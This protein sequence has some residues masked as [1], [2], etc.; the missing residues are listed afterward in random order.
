MSSFCG[1]STYDVH[2]YCAICGG[3][4]ADVFRTD[5]E[6]EQQPWEPDEDHE[7]DLERLEELDT[8]FNLPEDEDRLIPE[9]VVEQD[10]WYSS[11]RARRKRQQ[12]QA[13]GKR[14]GVIPEPRPVR[15]AY[16]G[17]FISPK[18][19]RWTRTLRALVDS[20]IRHQPAS[21][22]PS[23]NNRTY[24]TGRGRVRKAGS[25]ADA[26]SSFEDPEDNGDPNWIFPEDC[27]AA[28]DYGFHLYNDVD[29]SRVDS[30]VGSIPFHEECKDMLDMAID[31]VCEDRHLM[32]GIDVSP[33]VLWIRLRDL[34]AVS[35]Q[36]QKHITP[37]PADEKRQLVTRLSELDYREALSSGDGYQWRHEVGC[38]WV[39]ADP[40]MI[41]VRA[42]PLVPCI[43]SMSLR[44]PYQ[45]RQPPLAYNDP[46]FDRL[47]PEILL[48]ISSYLSSSDLFSLRCASACVRFLKIPQSFYQRFIEEDFRHLRWLFVNQ[49]RQGREA[50]VQWDWQ[51]SFE[52]LKGLIRTPSPDRPQEWS[53]VDIGLK[54]RHRI[55]KI[56]KPIADAI[57][58]T[59]MEALITVHNMP[60]EIAEETAVVRGSAGARSQQEG[61]TITA[62]LDGHG[63]S[64][65]MPDR[66]DDEQ[67]GEG[68]QHVG[69]G[70]DAENRM[71]PGPQQIAPIGPTNTIGESSDSQK[72][73]KKKIPEQKYQWLH[74]WWDA[75]PDPKAPSP[76]SFAPSSPDRFSDSVPSVGSLSPGYSIA[77][78][79]SSPMNITKPSSIATSLSSCSSELDTLIRTFR[80][81]FC[82][83]A[84]DSSDF[85]DKPRIDVMFG[86]L[87][88]KRRSVYLGSREIV[89]FVFSLMDGIIC[90]MKVAYRELTVAEKIIK[91]SDAFG[92]WTEGC[93]V[94]E[95]KLPTKWTHFMGLTGFMNSAGYFE[96]I[97]VLEQRTPPR[98]LLDMFPLTHQ[99]GSAWRY[100]RPIYGAIWDGPPPPYV[101]LRERDGPDVPD[102]RSGGAEWE[103]FLPTYLCVDGV[104]LRS[105]TGYSC[106]ERL[107]GLEFEYV[108]PSGYVERRVL[109]LLLGEK[110]LTFSLYPGEY[111]I[112]CVVSFGQDGVYSIQFV[113]S[114][115]RQSGSFGPKYRGSYTVFAPPPGML[116]P[117]KDSRRYGRREEINS[118]IVGLHAL[119][120][121]EE[122]VFLQL[123]IILPVWSERNQHLDRLMYSIPMDE[124]DET[125]C[126]W[127]DGSPPTDWI[128]PPCKLLEGGQR[129]FD[130]I[131]G[132][133]RVPYS[134]WVSFADLKRVVIYGAMRG[135]R[136]EYHDP[137]KPSRS[138]GDVTVP[139]SYTQKFAKGKVVKEIVE[140]VSAYVGAPEE[141]GDMEDDAMTETSAS[142]VDHPIVV[143]D[144]VFLVD[145]H[146]LHKSYVRRVNTKY[147]CGI[148]L[149][150]D[151][152][153]ILDWSPAFWPP[154][155]ERK[156]VAERVKHPWK[157][158]PTIYSNPVVHCS[159][160][161]KCI[162]VSFEPT[163]D[164][165][166]TAVK[167]YIDREGAF[168]GLLVRRGNV[169][170]EEV[171]GRRT[172]FESTFE[173]QEGEYIHSVFRTPSHCR[174]NNA[175][176]HGLSIC[177]TMGRV[178]PLFGSHIDSIFRCSSA[179][180]GVAAGIFG[181]YT[182]IPYH[183]APKWTN[184][185][186]LY[187]LPSSTPSLLPAHQPFPLPASPLRLIDPETSTPFLTPLP[188]GTLPPNLT[189]T[190][191]HPHRY[192][193]CRTTTTT[194][195]G[196]AFSL[197]SP[198]HLTQLRIW[199]L[200]GSIG[201][202]RFLGTREMGQVTV[203]EWP[204]IDCTRIPREH[205][206]SIDGPGGERISEVMVVWMKD[207]KQAREGR[208]IQKIVAV[209]VKTTWGREKVW[210]C[211]SAKERWGEEE[212][213]RFRVSPGMELVGVQVVA[214]KWVL[215]DLGLV[216]VRGNGESG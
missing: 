55:W 215:R 39:V 132:P 74:V 80:T 63:Q 144:L 163:R 24:L 81:A 9:E 124:F 20:D 38:H 120:D 119:Y 101:T 15:T 207:E 42:N 13:N 87:G 43:S 7:R 122:G 83:L 17:R 202:L 34:I 37:L 157:S 94:R 176:P 103:I 56:V 160:E 57:V 193:P 159:D 35:A 216:V 26:F 92:L 151:N 199:L 61:E 133:G 194:T 186:L 117:Q 19:M 30:L 213:E 51:A 166:V 86:R 141:R 31:A 128:V 8:S 77:S 198:Q 178:S 171:F 169:W 99:E 149:Q 59:S 158:D 188:T 109:G 143:G 197:I 66:G 71:G 191:L 97:E 121:Y 44:S 102:W 75:P 175:P 4:F 23:G 62:Y 111:F 165:T 183:A 185:G 69:G 67:P 73:V 88:T 174:V 138:F 147:L 205:R 161:V 58:H 187:R 1:G 96:T 210:A 54:N 136:F 170:D 154:G 189:F 150:F 182:D 29:G 115:N 33:D 98:P 72:K 6:P 142:T 100:R 211:G 106:E 192:P 177:T 145:H 14:R 156:A 11:K 93:V 112:A 52:S 27:L 82:G 208:V 36:K 129:V 214:E 28:N 50:G 89:G 196:R 131:L 76:R 168:A 105:I 140:L 25:W 40:S 84:F 48:M 123:G 172:G 135:I 3:P 126:I 184:L 137:A 18:Q 53:K 49:I 212:V 139:E 206:M 125:D 167:G 41:S 79:Q 204:D 155:N 190:P 195:L 146:T 70:Q 118:Q 21:G 90:G 113:T 95:I 130:T 10:M 5:V 47:P 201:G 164:G 16:D 110:S 179:S 108:Y 104:H 45:P 22:A 32:G 127:T 85:K 107:R 91:F 200:P 65:D 134:G 148:K 209:G 180:N 181:C 2:F 203:N 152:R 12:A 153:Q 116:N 162:S 64:R 60:E 46:Y 78:P 173:L 68:E 114:K